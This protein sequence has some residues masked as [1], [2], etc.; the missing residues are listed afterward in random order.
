LLIRSTTTP[1]TIKVKAR[2]VFEGTHTPTAAEIEF[3]SIPSGFEFCH[4]P[5]ERRQ[6]NIQNNSPSSNIIQIPDEKKRELLKEVEVQQ[7]EFG[8]PQQ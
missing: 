7:T 1:G 6:Q 5:Q 2:V 3:N 4:L 8:V